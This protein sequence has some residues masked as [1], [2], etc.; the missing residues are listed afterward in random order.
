MSIIACGISIVVFSVALLIASSFS[1]FSASCAFCSDKRLR[2]FSLYSSTELASESNSFAI[3]SVNSG[4]SLY[5]ISFTLVLNVASLPANSSAWYS[6]GNVTTTSFSSP[7]LTPT[8][9]S[10]NPGINEPEPISKS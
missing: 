7:V 4:T 3:S 9:W 2:K 1:T 5:L 8:N 6:S 10:S